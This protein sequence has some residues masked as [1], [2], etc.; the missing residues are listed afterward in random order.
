MTEKIESPTPPS[1]TV[2]RYRTDR[3]L[4]SGGMG[5]VYLAFDETLQRPIA[6][7]VLGAGLEAYASVRDRFLNE[8]RAQ[9]AMNHPNIATIY[10]VSIGDHNDFIA[11]E[12]I[13]GKTLKELINGRSLGYEEC[14]KIF[15]QICDGL[16]AAHERGIIHR[17]IKPG[18]IM[19]NKLGIAKILDFGLA[20]CQSSS[21]KTLP[22]TVMGTV[23]YMSPEQAMG[24]E[25]DERSDIFSLGILLYEMVTGVLPF[26]SDNVIS[27]MFALVHQP[28]KEVL[29]LR[30]SVPENFV[31]I[32]NRALEKEPV[33]R[34]QSV[35]EMAADMN[36][37]GTLDAT[38]MPKKTTSTTSIAVLAFE[39]QGTDRNSHFADGLGDEISGY[40]SRLSQLRVVSYSSSR[41][42]V[43][44]K[45]QLKQVSREL[46]ADFLVEGAVAW[47]E[48]GSKSFARIRVR[49]FRAD[50]ES[51]KWSETFDREIDQMFAVQSDVSEQVAKALGIL[52]GKPE[53]EMLSKHQT[54]SAD[55][56]DCFLRAN[57]L[58]PH[59]LS[60][61]STRK[62]IDLYQDATAIDSKFALAYARLSRA[63]ISMFWFHYDHSAVRLDLAKRA[64]DMA[65]SIEPDLPE[66]HQA[67]GFYHY[68]GQSDF[69]KALEQFHEAEELNPNDPSILA[70][71]AYIERRLGKWN[72]SLSSLQSASELDPRSAL[73]TYERGNTLLLMR[74]YD[75]A[76]TYFNRCLWLAPK[77]SDVYVKKAMSYLLR[78][79]SIDE[80]VNV[81]REAAKHFNPTEL[82]VEWILQDA[83]E[84]YYESDLRKAL[85]NLWIDEGEMEVHFMVRARLTLKT[86]AASDAASYFESARILLEAK[87]KSQP[88]DAR[89]Y[90]HL[91]ICYAG[92]NKKELAIQ[93]AERALAIVPPDKDKILSTFFMELQSVV[94]SMIDENEKSVEL[95][96]TLLLVP[97]NI[98]IPLLRNC[99]AFEELRKFRPFAELIG[100][101]TFGN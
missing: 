97:S 17:D 46:N 78:D 9:A 63:H 20:K 90:I 61:E 30:N 32:I 98:S 28:H 67:L 29:T 49:L 44:G 5:Q 8:A 62:A 4:G 38:G 73:I 31:R 39:N 18:N 94:Y 83:L 26:D 77:W 7:K 42:Y 99:S 13:E 76:I 81:I 84:K 72:E 37:P 40:L 1:S 2:S 87:A 101:T 85:D 12:Y 93:N 92:L 21:D 69:Q 52:L 10:E 91:A 50:D 25:V 96:R 100:S 48:S 82:A 23:R 56:Y 53:L 74:R 65:L 34:Y 54:S 80:S 15:R 66:A 70:S 79:W 35:A 43:P 11:M 51:L 24:K 86:E 6:L 41:Q 58:F 68:Y 88:T 14:S 71:L 16:T 59:N 75:E 57:E 19:M 64:V 36:S 3:L 27:V 89:L 55:A 22:G 45:R 60:E 33:N 95:L 47:D